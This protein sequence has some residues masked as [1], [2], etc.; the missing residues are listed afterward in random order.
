MPVSSS[1]PLTDAG[2][3][4]AG[5]SSASHQS[6]TLR[7]SLEEELEAAGPTPSPPVDVPGGGFRRAAEAGQLPHFAKDKQQQ[8]TRLVSAL[9]CHVLRT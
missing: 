5:A 6:S 8:Y 1:N 4:Y 2:C 7:A 9:Q 3:C